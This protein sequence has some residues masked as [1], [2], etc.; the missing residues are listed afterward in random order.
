MKAV[1]VFIFSVFLF[2]SILMAS[3]ATQTDW[4]G[5][6]GIL[7][8]VI[9]WG[10]EFYIGTDIDCYHSPSSI[11]LQKSIVLVPIEHTVRNYFSCAHTVYSADVNGDGYMDVLGAACFADDITW[12]ENVD[13]FRHR[14]DRTYR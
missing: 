9:D 1:V 7:G 14:L 13:G 8:P 6:A 4:S 12:W 10:N 3:S 11:L 2:P 5:G